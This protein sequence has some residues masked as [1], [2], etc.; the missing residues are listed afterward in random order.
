MDRVGAQFSERVESETGKL[1]EIS[2]QV[3]GSAVEV[4]SLGE[5]F[6]AAVQL[7]SA[8]TTSWPRSSNASRR[9]WTSPSPVATNSS[10]TTCRRRVKWWT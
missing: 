10:P 9:R 2:A 6:G 7:F 4:A 3:T 8:S 5:A 1:A